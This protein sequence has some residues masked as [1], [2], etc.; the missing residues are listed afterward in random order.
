MS[1]HT[2]S[3][4]QD[5]Q[6]PVASHGVRRWRQSPPEVLLSGRYFG[7]TVGNGL[8][9]KFKI[10]YHSIRKTGFT[11]PK[12]YKLFGKKTW[13]HPNTFIPN[14]YHFMQMKTDIHLFEKFSVSGGLRF[15][16]KL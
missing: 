12:L 3:E 16:F 5:E 1:V 2:K 4:V 6:P 7:E 15:R 8:K 13:N 9:L 14:P 11:R 10:K